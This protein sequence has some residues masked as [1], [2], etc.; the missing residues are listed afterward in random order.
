[1]TKEEFIQGWTL[2][3]AQPWGTRYARAESEIDRLTAKTQMDL[4]YREFAGSD[5][6][7]WLKAC[8][9]HAKGTKWPSIDELRISVRARPTPRSAPAS[10]AMTLAEFGEPLF[11][12][13]QWATAVHWLDQS[14]ARAILAGDPHQTISALRTRR[15]RALE[16]AKHWAVHVS[17][18]DADAAELARRY[19]WML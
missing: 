2:L 18:S 16:D 17:I 8:R 12:A 10:Q 1:M 7:D 15:A 11:A 3:I 5:A 6:D 13:I 19:P 4:Y 14:I 9:Q